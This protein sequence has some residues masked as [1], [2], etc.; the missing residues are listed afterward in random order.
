LRA[1]RPQWQRFLAVWLG[2][3]ALYFGVVFTLA[4][5]VGPKIAAGV[6]GKFWPRLMASEWAFIAGLVA[7]ALMAFALIASWYRL[8]TLRELVASARYAGRRWTLDVPASEFVQL[9]AGNGLL[10]V[11]TLGQAGPYTEARMLRLLVRNLSEHLP[12]EGDESRRGD[13]E[14]D[15]A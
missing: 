3:V 1:P 6:N 7:I 8:G 13:P 4:F 14:C 11:L 12:G 5:T 2:A 10:R 15:A 9:A